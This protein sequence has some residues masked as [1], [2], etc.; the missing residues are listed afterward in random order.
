MKYGKFMY[1][2]KIEKKDDDYKIIAFNS[3]YDKDSENKAI[4]DIKFVIDEQKIINVKSLEEGLYDLTFQANFI[5]DKEEY[6]VNY[7]FKELVNVT[8][9]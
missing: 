6:E 4:E 2:V 7:I 3:P 5:E 9:N 1:R 8:N